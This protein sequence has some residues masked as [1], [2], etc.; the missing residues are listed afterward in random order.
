MGNALEL[1]APFLA[2]QAKKFDMSQ[3]KDKVVIVHFWSSQSEYDIDFR[4][5]KLATDGKK[6]VE[7]VN[8]C[9][10]DSAAKAMQAARKVDAPGIHLFQAPN[11][12]SANPLGVHFGIQILPTMFVVGRDGRVSN[13]AVQV[14]DIETA[15]KAVQ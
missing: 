6:D 1:S 9:V 10:D 14:S 7:L 2:D 15:L 12:N 13:N 3:V 4:K 11:N 8:V 5:L